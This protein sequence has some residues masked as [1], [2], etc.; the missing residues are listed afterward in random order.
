MGTVASIHV[1]GDAGGGPVDEREVQPAIDACF[2]ELADLERIFSP[3]RADSDI[4]RIRAGVLAPADADCRVA[5][6]RGECE[7]AKRL[8]HGLFDAWHQGWFD[9][10]G[11]V[12]GWATETAARHRLEPLL[13]MDGVDAVGIGVGGDVQLF[14]AQG[15]D[16]RWHVGIADPAAPGSVAAT[17]EVRT[18]AVAT[19]GIAERGSHIID[20]RTGSPATTVASATVVADGLATA[21]LWAT[22]AVIAGFDDL[23]WTGAEGVRSGI[24][25]SPSGEIRRWAGSIELARWQDPALTRPS[26]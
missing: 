7:E 6:V 15:S 10:T 18:G 12:K 23:S 4:S 13:E 2:Q 21:D 9:P 17:I 22:T 8:T 1:L 25:I 19:S 16:W 20:P 26:R 11:Y 14:T 24:L 3:F 5:V